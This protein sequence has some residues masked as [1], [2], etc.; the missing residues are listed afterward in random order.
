MRI[1]DL[2]A[3][4][5]DEAKAFIRNCLRGPVYRAFIDARGNIAGEIPIAVL[6]KEYMECIGTRTNIVRLS[7]ETL[8]AHMHHPEITTDDYLNLQTIIEQAQVIVQDGVNTIVF[9]T[10]GNK[11]YHAV[12]KAT[13]TGEALFIT[14][15]RPTDK[16]DIERA[17]KTGKVIKK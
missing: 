9:I 7:A 8:G 2:S 6:P 5:P 16:K 14:S 13:K 17:K 1:P 12:I 4:S 3:Y 10:M 11:Y 15:L